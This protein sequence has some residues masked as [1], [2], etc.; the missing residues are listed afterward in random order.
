MKKILKRLLKNRHI[1]TFAMSML[2]QL[3]AKQY[4]AHP[5]KVTGTFRTKGG[6]SFKMYNDLREFLKP[7]W[8]SMLVPGETYKLPN[9]SDIRNR[10]Y[11]SEEKLEK[12]I[13]FLRSFDFHIKGK[14][15][16]EVGCY[17]GV[18]TFGL[19]RR[20]IQ[21]ITGSDVTF[22]YVNESAA[23][24]NQSEAQTYLNQLRAKT[25]AQF[26]DSSHIVPKVSFVD[27]NIN[28]T[29]LPHE[30]YDLIVSWE[31]LEHVTDPSA[32]LLNMKNLL[33]SGG[34]IYHEYN[35]FFCL[36]GGHSLCTLDFPW[37]HAL[38]NEEEMNNYLVQFRINEFDLAMKFYKES[39]NRMCM[40][41]VLQ[42]SKTLDL[43]VLAL[44][45]WIEKDHLNLYN[46]WYLSAIQRNYP[47]VRMHD[48]LSPNV[49]LVLK[50]K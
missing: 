14:R 41:D 46:H 9:S 48:L 2:R 28:N 34:I 50:K 30:S 43:E 24:S 8:R 33:K 36:T 18:K 39:L 26:N 35:P 25:L 19:A 7:D 12:L 15:I 3:Q 11:S 44:I 47:N 27:D 45:P 42:I 37:G 17:D 1:K 5:S 10:I 49:W 21:S 20:P 6:E 38:L 4:L 31:T 22:Y 13:Q 32:A 40:K 16:L 23:D 29:Q